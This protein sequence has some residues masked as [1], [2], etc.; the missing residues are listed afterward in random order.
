VI[1]RTPGYQESL[2]PSAQ[3]AVGYL[4]GGARLGWTTA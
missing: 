3:D 4:K 1:V 2:F